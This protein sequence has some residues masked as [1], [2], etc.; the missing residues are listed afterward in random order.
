MGLTIICPRCGTRTPY[1]TI[2]EEPSTA[3]VVW[4][5]DPCG[6]AWNSAPQGRP[7]SDVGEST[8]PQAA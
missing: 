2:H 4:A 6:F 3:S 5:C 1:R 8:S 7:D